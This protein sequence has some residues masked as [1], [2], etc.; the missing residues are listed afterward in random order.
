MDAEIEVVAD[1]DT[2][3]PEIAP[4]LRA[5]HEHHEPLVGRRLLPDWEERQRQHLEGLLATGDQR[6]L[7]ARLEGRAVGFANGAL[8][9]NPAVMAETFGTIDNVYVTPEVRG[10]GLASQLVRALEGWFRGRGADAV[11]L[12]VVAANTHAVE[13]WTAMGFTPL[14]Y[15]MTRRLD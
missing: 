8:R 2:R 13:V 4:L 7:L 3:W 15:R 9:V 11:Q 14:S 5:L 6:I 1:L 12:S 10:T